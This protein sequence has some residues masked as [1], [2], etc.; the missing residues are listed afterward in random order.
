[1]TSLCMR[2]H[3]C[4]P[5]HTLPTD[6]RRQPLRTRRRRTS[7]YFHTQSRL[8]LTMCAQAAWR[9]SRMVRR[10]FHTALLHLKP[11]PKPTC[12][13][14]TRPQPPF[15]EAFMGCV[16]TASHARS[17]GRWQAVHEV[18]SARG[19]LDVRILTTLMPGG[20]CADS[21]QPHPVAFTPYPG[22]W[23]STKAHLPHGLPRA[24]AL[25]RLDIPQRIPHRRGRR[26][27]IPAHDRPPNVGERK[28][29]HVKH[30]YPDL[31]SSTAL[32]GQLTKSTPYA[33]AHSL[34][35]TCYR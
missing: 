29:R 9:L 11:L 18:L 32:F 8:P 7:R 19:M 13:A 33:A 24:H 12:R 35:C 30:S 27:A 17:A 20:T 5:Q 31:L 25:A 14:A 2:S 21:N 26:V 6:T 3:D 10:A 28:R 1:M 4:A 23:A 15:C 22:P 34:V 16:L